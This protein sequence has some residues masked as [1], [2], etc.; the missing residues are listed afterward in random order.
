MKQVMRKLRKR[1]I[2]SFQLVNFS[3]IKWLQQN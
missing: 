3:P 1:F 2:I